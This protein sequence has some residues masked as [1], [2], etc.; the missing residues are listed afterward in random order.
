IEGVDLIVKRNGLTNYGQVFSS[1]CEALATCYNNYYIE[2]FQ[3][4]I[5]NYFI[6]MVRGEDIHYK[7]IVFKRVS[8]AVLSHE[9]QPA[10]DGNIAF[11]LNEEAQG[12][13]RALLK[14]LILEIRNRLPSFP[15]TK[16]TLN[17][18]PSGIIPALRYILVKYEALIEE[19]LQP[20]PGLLEHSEQTNPPNRKRPKIEEG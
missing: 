8:N 11:S 12:N 20:Q 3:T 6:Y 5:A 7:Y 1:A 16:E 17:K 2:Y 19:N 4:F 15:M 10:M 18:A 9:V 13:I 14:L